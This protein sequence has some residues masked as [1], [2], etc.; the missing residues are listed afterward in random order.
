MIPFDAPPGVDPDAEFRLCVQMSRFTAMLDDG[1]TVDV[2]RKYD[3]WVVD[4]RCYTL[5]DLEKDIGSRVKW[6]SRQQI[7][8]YEYEVGSGGERKLVDDKALSFAFSNHQIDKRMFV[9]VEVEE[10]PAELISKSGV[11]EMQVTATAS[12]STRK[13][14]VAVSA[15]P[16]TSK[17]QV[18]VSASPSTPPRKKKMAVRKKYTPRKANK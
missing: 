13:M 14:Q 10:K 2:P 7:V 6:G 9:F 11:T 4:S 18:A 16:S 5:G 1:S 8:M 15:S 3:E 12:P 17:M